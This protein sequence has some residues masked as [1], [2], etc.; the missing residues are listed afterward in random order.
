MTFRVDLSRE[1]KALKPYLRLFNDQD[2]IFRQGQLG[3]T[4]FI[5]LTGTIHLLLE[6]ELGEHVFSVAN[7]GDLLG[8]KAL[9]SPNPHPRVFSA[10]AQNAVLGVELSFANIVQLQNEDPDLV[11]GILRKSIEVSTKRLSQANYLA[12]VLRQTNGRKRF[13]DCLLYIA[14]ASGTLSSDKVWIPKMKQALDYYL[15]MDENE[16]EMLME[17]LIQSGALEAQ[18]KGAYLLSVEKMLTLSNAK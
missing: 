15:G 5:V 14:Q 7:S 3:N 2:I 13:F 17:E 12:R 4:V 9:L 8:E 18:E 6:S 1:N 11:L 16:Q 10:Q